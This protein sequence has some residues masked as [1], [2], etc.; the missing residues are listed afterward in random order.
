MNLTIDIGNTLQKIAVFNNDECVHCQSFPSVTEEIL[1]AVLNQFSIKYSIISSVAELDAQVIA[2]LNVHTKIIHY[3]HQ[4]KLPVTILYKNAAT[5]GL[6]RIANAVGS[7]ALFPAQNVLSIQ[8][9]TCLVLDFVNKNGEYLGGSISPGM[10]MRFE[11]LHE[12]T[13]NLP[14]INIQKVSFTTKGTK[15]AQGTQSFLGTDTQSS[16]SSGVINGMCYEI[17]G[18]IE[19]YKTNFEN[20]KVILTGGDAAYLQ[21][22]IKNTIFAAPNVVLKGL[23][24]IIKYN[25]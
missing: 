17:D 21:N 16:L 11:V 12:K 24:E 13:K 25:V 9:G 5:L 10:K 8:A 19:S 4:T 22:S 1:I 2:F 23:N 18:F 3:T 6:D 20:L 7:A 15:E 14:L